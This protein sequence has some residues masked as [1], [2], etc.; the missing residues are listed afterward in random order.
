MALTPTLYDFQISLSDTERGVDQPALSLKAARHPSETME[1]LWL[2]VLAFCAV[3]EERLAFSKGGLS[4]PDSPDLECR[5]YTGQLTRW[6]RVGKPDPLRIQKEMDQR[7]GAKALVLFDSPERMEAFL[8]EAR[9]AKA[10]RVAKAELVAVDPEL[11]RALAAHDGRRLKATFTF[12]GDH[13][14]AEVDGES[15]DGPITRGA[16]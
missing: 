1:R 6:A 15:V 16:L 11:L 3:W 13:L 7:G 10:L 5:D 14:Y 8:V 4:D 9:E 12:V 2:R